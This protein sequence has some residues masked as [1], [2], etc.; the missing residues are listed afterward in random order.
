MDRIF[1]WSAK[2]SLA[3]AFWQFEHGYNGQAFLV[4]FQ[5]AVNGR[6]NPHA[7]F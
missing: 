4:D 3:I 6:P 1:W 5:A 7:K 2:A